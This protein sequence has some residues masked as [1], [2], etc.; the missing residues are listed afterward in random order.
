MPTV[1][2]GPW[3]NGNVGNGHMITYEV[4]GGILGEC[5]VHRAIEAARFVDVALQCI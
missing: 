3:P 4:S 2:G 5:L 1:R